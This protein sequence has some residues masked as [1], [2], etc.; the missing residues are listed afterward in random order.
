MTRKKRT[1]GPAMEFLLPL[2]S[3]KGP[4]RLAKTATVES[5]SFPQKKQ[6]GGS[7]YR[8]LPLQTI[9]Q[10]RNCGLPLQPH[11]KPHVEGEVEQVRLQEIY[12]RLTDRKLSPLVGKSN[13]RTVE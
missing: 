4:A 12:V 11:A 10:R 3:V 8:S 1:K 13:L 6:E 2:K 5:Y 7:A 9:R